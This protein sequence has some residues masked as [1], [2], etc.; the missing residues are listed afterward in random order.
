VVRRRQAVVV[1]ASGE[2]TAEATKSPFSVTYVVM[3]RRNALTVQELDG[4]VATQNFVVGGGQNRLLV[5]RGWP[6]Q[7]FAVEGSG[8]RPSLAGRN[9]NSKASGRFASCDAWL[10]RILNANAAMWGVGSGGGWVCASSRWW[11][12]LDQYSAAA[13]SRW[14]GEC[15]GDEAGLEKF[16]R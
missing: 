2:I 7:G 8:P 1:S 10:A 14:G 3:A 12:T 9:K 13:K 16:G 5:F 15:R 11:R 4:G 6:L